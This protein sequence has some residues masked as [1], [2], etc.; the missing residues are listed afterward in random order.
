VEQSQDETDARASVLSATAAGR[1]LYQRITDDLV[2]QQKELLAD[3]P[4]EIRQGVIQTIQRLTRAADVRF[5]SG[6]SVAASACCVP[7]GETGS[8]G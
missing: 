1:R 4:A 3:L 8:C 7:G 5:R 2:T 6:V